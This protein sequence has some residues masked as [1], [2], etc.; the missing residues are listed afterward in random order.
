MGRL[1]RLKDVEA[2]IGVENQARTTNQGGF[3]WLK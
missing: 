2:H 3:L 1:K